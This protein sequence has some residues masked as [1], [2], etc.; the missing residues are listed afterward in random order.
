MNLLN[1]T[2]YVLVP[3][4]KTCGGQKAISSRGA[5]KVEWAAFGCQTS[6]LPEHF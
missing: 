5:K 1:D 4:M 2:A 6:A 3:R